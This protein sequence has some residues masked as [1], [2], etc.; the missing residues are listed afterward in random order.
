[1]MIREGA[2]EGNSN[3]LKHSVYRLRDQGP[4][5][6]S[7]EQRGKYAELTE[8]LSTRLGAINALREQAIQTMLL[9]EIAQSY[10][11]SEYK[12]GKVLDD[13]QLLRSLPAFWNSA[14]RALKTYL[15]V[16]PKEENRLTLGEAIAKE[17]ELH[18]QNKA[19]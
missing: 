11:V 9:A 14:N 18:E 16:L 12:T 7:S 13:I 1:M 5:S 19:E 8:Q 2:P 3:S 15:D 17:V 10:C 4:D 6:L